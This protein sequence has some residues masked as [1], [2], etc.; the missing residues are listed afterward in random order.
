MQQPNGASLDEEI[1]GLVDRICQIKQDLLAV[2]NH[3]TGSHD[4]QRKEILKEL[5][6]EAHRLMLA[7]Q[8]PQEAFWELIRRVSGAQGDRYV[9]LANVY[10]SVP[11]CLPSRW[12]R[13]LECFAICKTNLVPRRRSWQQLQGPRSLS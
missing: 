3:A 8:E 7:T 1:V 2:N 9:R 13:T 11:Y 6:L 12:H 5:R 4:F 10:S